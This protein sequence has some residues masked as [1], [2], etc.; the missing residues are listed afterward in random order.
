MWLRARAAE[1]HE[2]VTH[3][4]FHRRERREKENFVQRMTTRVYTADEGEFY[5]ID[6]L[7]AAEL[8]GRANSELRKAG[9][10]PRGF[11]APAWLLSEEGESALR[12]EG[13]E[14]TTRLRVVTDLKSGEV[15]ESRS[16]CWSVRSAWRR[17][18]SV[19]WNAVLYRVLSGAPL[20]RISIHPVDIEHVSVWTQIRCL[21]VD[22]LDSRTPMTYLEWITAQRAAAA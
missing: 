4:Y 21:I 18:M 2:I 3:G 11:I 10:D 17:T 13:C 8:V 14:Y 20:L 6:R 15:Y 9:F 19:V 5:D 1:G 22:A 12:D 16:L 7:R